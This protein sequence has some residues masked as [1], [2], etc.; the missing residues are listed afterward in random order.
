MIKVTDL[1][2]WAK[3]NAVESSITYPSGWIRGS[4]LEKLAIAVKKK[5]PFEYAPTHRVAHETDDSGAVS[6]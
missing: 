2:S 4:D 6:L 1:I 5:E 3:R